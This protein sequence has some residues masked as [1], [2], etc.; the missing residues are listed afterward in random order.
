V[1]DGGDGEE[2][3]KRGRDPFHG[4]RD[5]S[6]HVGW[7]G[8]EEILATAAADG[9]RKV[10]YSFDAF[11]LFAL[12]YEISQWV[13]DLADDDSKNVLSQEWGIRIAV[14][15]ENVEGRGLFL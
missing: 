14:L 8:G 12:R 13:V 9:E 3:G 15:I 4:V 11:F 2:D 10:A 1:E 6:R 5:V 7:G